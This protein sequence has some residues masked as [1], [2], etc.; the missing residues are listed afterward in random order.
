MEAQKTVKGKRMKKLILIVFVGAAGMMLSS[1]TS[2]KNIRQSITTNQEDVLDI[3]HKVNSYWQQNH[4]PKQRAFWDVAAYHTGNLEA[5]FLTKN[6]TYRKYSEDWAAHNQW[7][8]AKSMNKAEWK[9]SYGEKDEYVL[10]GDWQI[11]F[12]TYIE[13]KMITGGGQMDFTW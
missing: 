2:Q 6:E 5:Y 7:M 4:S 9:Y 3:I 8:G 11:C 10:F 1:C 12:Q 13:L